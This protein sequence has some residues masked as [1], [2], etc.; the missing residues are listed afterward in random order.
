MESFLGLFQT[1]F[2]SVWLRVQVA[3]GPK[4]DGQNISKDISPFWV[5]VSIPLAVN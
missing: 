2:S 1:D 5:V 4:V 3:A